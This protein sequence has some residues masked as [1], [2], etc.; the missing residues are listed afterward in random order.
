M[1]QTDRGLEFLNAQV[2]DVFRK[3]NIHHYFSLNDDIKAALVERFNRTLKSRLYRYMTHHRT[4]RWIDA[5]NDI[6][7]S[8]NKSR[9]RSIG[10]APIEVTRDK[11]EE[12]AKRLYPPKPALRYKYDIGDRV[13]IVKYKHV[14]QKGYI[15]NWTEE[16]FEIADRNPTFPVTYVLKD[17]AGEYIKGKFYEQEIQKVVKTDD[18]YDIEKVLKTRRRGGKIEQFV[19]WKGYP[20]KFNSWI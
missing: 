9:H 5:L 16:M 2:Q 4:S 18:V 20:D 17:L 14:L 7:E 1:L 8:Y 13:R 15:P 3:H 19:K 12:I 6:V 10:M 11:E